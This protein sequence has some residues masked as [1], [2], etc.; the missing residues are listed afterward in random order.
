MMQTF[1]D[2]LNELLQRS[3]NQLFIQG[4]MAQLTYTSFE[5]NINWIS[6]QEEGYNLPISYPIGYQADGT[7]LMSEERVYTKEQLTES[8]NT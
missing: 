5:Q 3:Q 4:E 8:T 2:K 6:S 1:G 7:P